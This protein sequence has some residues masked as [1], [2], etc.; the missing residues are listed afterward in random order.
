MSVKERSGTTL[1][2]TPPTFGGLVS[3]TAAGTSATLAWVAGSDT[4][5]PPSA[6]TYSVYVATTTFAEDFTK[7]PAYTGKGSGITINGLKPSTKYFFVVRAR[8]TA[9]NEDANVVEKSCTTAVSSDV[10]PPSFPGVVSV[11]PSSRTTLDLAWPEA[12]DDFSAPSNITY[13]IFV[14]TTAGGEDF[15]T[16]TRTVVGATKYT[17]TG[18]KAATTYYVVVRARDEGGNTDLNKNEK[19]ATTLP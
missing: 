1:D 15:T 13:E 7:P 3:A 4:V 11:S 17:V 5:D 14:A 10:T 12:I 2:I 6:L 19:S 16:T 18:L 9:G 8:D